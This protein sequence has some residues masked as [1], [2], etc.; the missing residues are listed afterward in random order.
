MNQIMKKKKILILS[1]ILVLGGLSSWL[2]LYSNY[3]PPILMYHSFDKEK[4]GKYASVSPETFT[5]QMEFIKKRGYAVIPIDE[6][7]RL[8]RQNKKIPHN[9]VVITADDG[10]KDNLQAIDILDKFDYPA[11]IFIILNKISEEEYLSGRD[12]LRFL[13]DTRVRIGSHT[14]SHRYLPEAEDQSLKKEIKDSKDKLEKAFP[15]KVEVIAYPIGGFDKRVL[16]EV[17][18]AGYLCAC[19]TNRGFS[20]DLDIFALRRIK[21]TER[22]LGIRLWAKLSG[23]YN[24]FR[25]VK[26]PY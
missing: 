5:K 21:V 24:I 7:C 17:E 2:W 15:V 4:V 14:L 8:F 23:F 16:K 26:H 20:R 25:K 12:I 10:Y 22:D 9:V 11:T 13:K 6:L 3:S 1:F 19:S 18:A